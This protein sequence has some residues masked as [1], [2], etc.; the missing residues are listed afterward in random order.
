MTRKWRKRDEIIEKLGRTDAEKG[1]GRLED[2]M[3][4]RGEGYI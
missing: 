3:K 2:D 4:P 1:E